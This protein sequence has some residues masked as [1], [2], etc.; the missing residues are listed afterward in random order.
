VWFVARQ[1][2]RDVQCSDLCASGKILCGDEAPLGSQLQT[3][4]EMHPGWEAAPREDD[5][6]D[7]DD[8]VSD[9]DTDDYEEEDRGAYLFVLF[10][11]LLVWLLASEFVTE[12]SLSLED[13]TL[14]ILM[15]EC[16]GRW[17]V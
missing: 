5:D 16:V 12:V 8:D 13:L 9:D 15:Y 4:L 14:H 2:G 1:V 10:V 6:D 3:W 11:C 17:D 7:D